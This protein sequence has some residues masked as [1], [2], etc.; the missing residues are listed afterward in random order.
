[1]QEL[2]KA[3]IE[4][5]SKE[6]ETVSTYQMTFRARIGFTVL[7]GPF[8]VMGSVL[9][10]T[11]G[12]LVL[13]A[14]N[15]A[16][17]SAAGLAAFLYCLFGVWGALHENHLCFLCDQWRDTI[18]RYVG[19]PRDP[20]KLWG[21][22]FLMAL[23]GYLGGCILVLLVF[24]ATIYCL[25]YVLPVRVATWSEIMWTVEECKTELGAEFTTRQKVIDFTKGWN[26]GH[27]IG[28]QDE[29]DFIKK[30]IDWI[31]D[32]ALAQSRIFQLAGRLGV[33]F[34]AGTKPPNLISW[35]AIGI[36]ILAFIVSTLTAR[37]GVVIL[38]DAK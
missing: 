29:A 38:S 12:K 26:D 27:Y 13:P 28:D 2:E 20:A 3:H 9:I 18:A 7:I 34:P 25:S 23:A 4:Y 6:I 10:A 35:F 30:N 11:K 1:M 14:S 16:F 5:L 33:S 15:T 31:A 22:K 8:I 36:S 17:Y 21:K 24:F 19:P 37:R 32:E